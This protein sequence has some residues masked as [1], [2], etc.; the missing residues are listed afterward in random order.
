MHL[1]DFQNTHNQAIKIKNT[2]PC[3]CVI[4]DTIIFSVVMLWAQNSR[5]K[6]HGVYYALL[7]QDQFV[8]KDI[9][10]DLGFIMS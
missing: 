8:F 3:D 1:N 7:K 5:L 10:Y 9:I 2:H 4:Y 6:K